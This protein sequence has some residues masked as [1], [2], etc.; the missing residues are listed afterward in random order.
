MVNV[1]HTG[2]LKKDFDPSVKGNVYFLEGHKLIIPSSTSG[3]ETSKLS[4][5]NSNSLN[6]IHRYLIFQLFLN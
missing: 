5:S 2:D 3:A 1:P 6:I 4:A